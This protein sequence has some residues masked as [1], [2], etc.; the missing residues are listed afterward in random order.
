M[1]RLRR[2]MAGRGARVRAGRG[3][4]RDGGGGEGGREGGRAARAARAARHGRPLALAHAHAH[5][6]GRGGG[7]ARP[8]LRDVSAQRKEGA[9]LTLCLP[10][11]PGRRRSLSGKPLSGGRPAAAGGGGGG[12]GELPRGCPPP[13]SGACPR[14]LEGRGVVVG[15]PQPRPFS[16]PAGCCWQPPFVRRV[17]GVLAGG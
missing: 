4:E 1:G 8:L 14:R 5:T 3:A 7:G 12:G 11:S 13:G 15:A 16:P 17:S 2:S 6:P 9:A 10:R